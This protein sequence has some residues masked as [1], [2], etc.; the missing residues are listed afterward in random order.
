VATCRRVESPQDLARCQAE[1]V[2]QLRM[3]AFPTLRYGV[4]L[5]GRAAG[6]SCHYCPG[7]RIESVKSCESD[8]L[9]PVKIRSLPRKRDEV[10]GGNRRQQFLLH[11]DFPYSPPQP[12]TSTSIVALAAARRLHLAH[13]HEAAGSSGG[14]GRCSSNTHPCTDSAVCGAISSTLT[15]PT[16]PAQAPIGFRIHER[17]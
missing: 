13:V 14:L 12:C 2:V 16:C 10:V 9:T 3:H 1:S 4:R 5:I 15:S 17:V 11:N 8:L 7:H 6:V